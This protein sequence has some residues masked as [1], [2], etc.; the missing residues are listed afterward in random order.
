MKSGKVPTWVDADLPPAQQCA[1]IAALEWL[2]TRKISAGL[3]VMAESDGGEGNEVT[4]QVHWRA[5]D[6]SGVLVAQCET[7]E[8]V[9]VDTCAD[10]DEGPT[11]S[12]CWVVKDI[13]PL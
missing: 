11:T 6:T 2:Q 1:E 4:V 5:D 9:R 13:R 7:T 10:L 12:A 8:V 3:S